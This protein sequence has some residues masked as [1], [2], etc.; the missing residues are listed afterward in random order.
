[1]IYSD[2]WNMVSRLDLLDGVTM[3]MPGDQATVRLTVGSEM[4]IF[5]GQ[6]YTIRDNN[7]TV[8][9][10]IVTRLCKPVQ[11]DKVDKNRLGKL[12]INL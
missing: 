2:T 3:I 10:G 1:M 4:P 7:K 12:D 9:T 8:A 6:N 5:K 11:V